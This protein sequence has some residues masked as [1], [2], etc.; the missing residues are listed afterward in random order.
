[1]SVDAPDHTLALLESRLSCIP[2]LDQQ[3]FLLDE[4]V[5]GVKSG[6]ERNTITT[7]S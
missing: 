7:E 6:Q 3:S 5:S 4:P 2:A 1:M